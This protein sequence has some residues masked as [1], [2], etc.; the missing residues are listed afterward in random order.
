M[1]KDTILSER[2]LASG[3]LIYWT[4]VIAWSNHILDA[5]WVIFFTNSNF[6]AVKPMSLKIIQWAYNVVD[7][8]IE[9]NNSIRQAKNIQNFYNANTNTKY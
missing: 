4:F 7:L 8:I 5:F 1:F 2:K 9:D 6:H 3:Y